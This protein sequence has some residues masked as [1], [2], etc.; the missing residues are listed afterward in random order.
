MTD[1]LEKGIE[2]LNSVQD[3]LNQNNPLTGEQKDSFRNNGFLLP[4]TYSADGNGLPY[5]KVPSERNAQ[6]K[7]NIV[8]WF[9]PQFGIV[10]MYINPEQISY[11]NKKLI[12]KDKTKGGYTLQYWGEDLTDITISGTTGSSGIEGINLLYEIYRAEQLAFDGVGLT[13]AAN[14][15]NNDLSHNLINGIGGALGDA[16]GGGKGGNAAAVG[17]GAIGTLFGV[18]SP[19][20]TMAS[21]NFPSLAQLAFSVEMFY[22]GWVY[23]GFFETMTFNEKANNFLIDYSIKF[24]ATQRRGYRANYFPWSRNP[25]NGPS[26]YETPMSFSNSKQNIPQ[27]TAEQLENI[28]REAL[29]SRF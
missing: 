12:N 27:A 2:G 9:V 4:P 1:F 25:A 17:V 29:K 10:R 6:P 16:L 24:T 14:N 5:S 19:N 28:T 7:R 22:N 11:A 3:F 13:I 15:Y 23:R 20:N 26:Q 8:T 18:D 21:K